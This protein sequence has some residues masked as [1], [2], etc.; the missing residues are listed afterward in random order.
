MFRQKEL[1]DQ[2]GYVVVGSTIK[3]QHRK[4]LFNSA[5]ATPESLPLASYGLTLSLK[6]QAGLTAADPARVDEYCSENTPGFLVEIILQN[7]MMMMICVLWTKYASDRQKEKLLVPFSSST[8]FARASV[9]GPKLQLA[10]S[11]RLWTHGPVPGFMWWYATMLLLPSMQSDLE[12]RRESNPNSKL[13]HW[14]TTLLALHS[15][16]FPFIFFW[17]TPS[18][19][20][21]T[22][23]AL[24]SLIIGF[25]LTKVS[26]IEVL[27]ICA[28]CP[29]LS[30]GR[31]LNQ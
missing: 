19:S 12:R 7:V 17:C 14:T 11:H 18:P 1:L 27:L 13:L 24:A 9:S 23:I 25:Y 5:R 26:I 30:R 6:T 2:E 28:Y 29:I 21:M 22:A 15:S 10:S 20:K 3:S 4:K 16:L 31:R 8:T